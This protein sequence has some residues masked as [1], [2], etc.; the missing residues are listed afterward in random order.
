MYMI[1]FIN[2]ESEGMVLAVWNVKSIY[3]CKERLV[4]S[5]WMLA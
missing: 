3:D 4:G 1:K 5:T 2:Y